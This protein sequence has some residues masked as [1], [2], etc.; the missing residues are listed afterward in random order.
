MHSAIMDI[1]CQFD[2]AARGGL[3]ALQHIE[4]Y[5]LRVGVV[6]LPVESVD[7]VVEDVVAHGAEVSHARAV[8][9]FVRWTEVCWEEA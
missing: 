1:V 4:E 5:L 8:A 6:L 3:P 7:V 9:A 2:E